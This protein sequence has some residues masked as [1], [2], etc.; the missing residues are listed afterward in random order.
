M[1]GG[2]G[3]RPAGAPVEAEHQLG[4]LCCPL[5]HCLEFT[6]SGKGDFSLGRVHAVWTT[7][8]CSHAM[9]I[10]HLVMIFL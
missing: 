4:K 9:K 2:L 7:A 6:D 1:C 10:E 5:G 8:T 3:W